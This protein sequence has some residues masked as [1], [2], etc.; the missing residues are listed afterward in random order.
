MPKVSVLMP[1]YN[2][3]PFVGEAIAGVL[4]QTFTDFELI[5]IDDG[6]TDSTAERVA[7]FD[8]PRIRLVRTEHA[9]LVAAGNRGLELARGAYIWRVD[10]DDIPMPQ[11]LERQVEVLDRHPG[12]AAV[13]VWIRVFGSKQDLWRGPTEP[14]PIRRTL[15][16]TNALPQPVVY[17]REGA[18]AAGGY[19]AVRWEDW[20]LWVR[21]GA[22]HDLRAVPE[23]LAMVRV[24]AG[25]LYWSS[26]RLD[27]KRTN[28]RMQLVAL[29]HLGTDPRSLLALLRTA[30]M[31]PVVALRDPH[32]R[33]LPPTIGPDNA[34]DVTVVVT[35]YRRTAQLGRCLEG[36]GGQ[37]PP[38]SEVVVVHR[39]GDEET[40][41]FLEEWTAADPERH[42]VAEV[43]RPGI[44]AALVTG[45]VAAR[46]DIVAFLDDDAVPREGWLAE[47]RRGFLD[48]TVGGVGGRFVDHIDGRERRGRTRDVGRITWYGRVIGRHDLDTDY[49][50]DVEILPGAN[51]AFRRG[52]IHHDER[53]LHTS[54][55]L[56]LANELDACLTVRRLGHRLLYTPWAVVDHYTTSY[57]DPKLG[58]RVAG[59]DVFT[60]A[61]NY[62]YALL[63][64]LPAHRRVAFLLYAYLLG[65]SMLPG[66]GR[67]LAALPS[68]PRRAWA[69]AQRIPATWRGRAAGIR[70]YRRW[71]QEGRP[72][73]APPAVS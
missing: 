11:L 9:G 38:P 7:A 40:L 59:A 65:S 28:L 6:S 58:S 19:R 3:A 53:L 45:T 20:D 73:T 70:M 43:E 63:K 5:V 31:I 24:R 57:R 50:G 26:R 71:R 13:G 34:T 10:G 12:T 56:A 37:V 25:S 36:I 48:A 16:R 62:T 30:L 46:S 23:Y 51:M 42:R 54:G 67:V 66:P 39:R 22:R 4:A 15:R 68:G 35:T 41:E 18:L 21:L 1:T 32:P 49:Y 47:L 52:L 69:M 27:I 33:R 8:D 29:R 61:A 17:R 2:V 60:S 14:A 55:G 64:Y 44:V 72:F